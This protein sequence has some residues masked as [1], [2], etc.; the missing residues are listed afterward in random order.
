MGW[1]GVW[2]YLSFLKVR[3]LDFSDLV[4]GWNCGV[5][6]VSSSLEICWFVHLV[7][8]QLTPSVDQILVIFQISVLVGSSN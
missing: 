7:E 4:R 8:N 3:L 1:I 2:D 6:D 5:V